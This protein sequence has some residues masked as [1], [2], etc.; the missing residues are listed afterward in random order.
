M[1]DLE[2]IINECKDWTQNTEAMLKQR[3]PRDTGR[4]SQS[5]QGKVKLR[6]GVPYAIAYSFERYLAYRMKGA[7]RGQAGKKGSS[8][9]DKQGTRKRTNPASLGK[10][11]TGNRQ[12]TDVFNDTIGNEL[13]QLSTAISRVMADVILKYVY[14]GVY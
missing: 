4:A 6:N 2:E 9:Y 14:Q 12:A 10:M 13:P 11:N 8:W 7:G 5:I 3:V 1:S